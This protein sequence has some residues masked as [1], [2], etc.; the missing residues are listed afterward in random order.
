MHER[1]L[2]AARV[3]GDA[4]VR[5]LRRARRAH[6]PMRWQRP[7]SVRVHVPGLN[8]ADWLPLQPEENVEDYGVLKA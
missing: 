8:V 2:A 1:C 7:S 4:T 6:G 5:A 3:R